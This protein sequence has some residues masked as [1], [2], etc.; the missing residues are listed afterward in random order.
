MGL[1]SV[2]LV[3]NT[4]QHFG[5]DIPDGVAEKLFTVGDLHGFIVAE[6][7]RG[8]REQNPEAV[9]I[10][11]RQLICDQFGIKPK[12]V[13]AEARIVKDLGID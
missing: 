13:L 6:L 10:E 4:E 11:L 12:R 1:D 9:F 2:E 7:K 8:G 3:M 5:I